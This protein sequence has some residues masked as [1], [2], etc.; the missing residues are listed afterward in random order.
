MS[1]WPEYKAAAQ[2]YDIPT[3]FLDWT[4]D[5]AVAVWFAHWNSAPPDN[6]GIVYFA[7]YEQHPQI[8]L[9]LPPPFVKRLFRERGFFH[10]NSFRAQE[11]NVRQNDLLYR[12][13]CRIRFPLHD[14]FDVPNSYPLRDERALRTADELPLELVDEAK[15]IANNVKPDHFEGLNSQ[16]FLIRQATA[17][18]LRKEFQ[19]K[20]AALSAMH[21]FSNQVWEELRDFWI[22][23]THRFINE[24]F[25]F[26]APNGKA[27]IATDSVFEMIP[28]NWNALDHYC[29]WMLSQSGPEYKD[30]QWFLLDLRKRLDHHR[31]KSEDGKL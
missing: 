17:M 7:D 12:Q 6:E 24:L 9:I 18:T 20:I 31:K 26:E 30:K 5:P 19:D 22:L 15:T 4:V 1:L 23:E 13:S 2:H 8:R 10:T 21:P 14:A 16:Y 3:E 29:T 11:E 28:F 27:F 25:Q